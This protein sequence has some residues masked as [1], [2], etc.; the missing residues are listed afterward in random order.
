MIS[1]KEKSMESISKIEDENS[2]KNESACAENSVYY[3]VHIPNDLPYMD[4]NSDLN[5]FGDKESVLQL[6]KQHKRARFKAFSLYHEAADFAM[7]GSENA[8]NN[9]AIDFVPIVNSPQLLGEKPSPFKGPKP[10]DMIILRKSIEKGDYESIEVIIWKNPRYLISSGDTPSIL[11]EGF[12]YNALH[13]AAKAKNAKIAELILNTVSNVNFV[14]LLYGD[15]NIENSKERANVFLDL[16]LNTPDKGLNET[17]LHFAVKYGAAEVVEVLVSY[18]QCDKTVKNKYGKIP[19]EI[20]C[21]RYDISDAKLYKRIK[22]LLEETYYVPVLR[23]EDNSVPPKIGEPFSPVNPPVFNTHPSSPRLE[24]QAYAGPMDKEG[25]EHFRKVWKTPPRSLKFSTPTKKIDS[26]LGSVASMKYKDPLKGLE[27]VGKSLASQ[28]DISWKEYWPFLDS[29]VDIA[30][31]EGLRLLENHLK[32]RVLDTSRSNASMR[33]E[34]NISDLCQILQAFHINS[35]ISSAENSF[36]DE[37][38]S[39]ISKN[40]SPFLCLEKACEVFATRFANNILNAVNG[41][42][43]NILDTEMKQ[44]EIVILSYMDDNRFSNINFK[45]VHCRLSNL[46]AQKLY[47][48]FNEE[49]EKI[50]MF[51]KIE[52]LIEICSKSFDCF[53]SDDES[54]NSKDVVPKK[55]TSIKKQLLCLAH[56]ILSQFVG[57]LGPHCDNV[58]EEDCVEIWEGLTPCT[59]VLYARRSRKN[60]NFQRNN[61]KKYTLGSSLDPVRRLFQEEKEEMNCLDENCILSE[62]YFTPTATPDLSEEEDDDD[63]FD[64]ARSLDDYDAYIEG[65]FPSKTDGAVF[66]AIKYSGCDIDKIVYPNIYLWK[67][68]VAQFSDEERMSWRYQKNADSPLSCT[69]PQKASLPLTSTPSKSWLRITG[70]NSPKNIKR[71]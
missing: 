30:S 68:N 22:Q 15:D 35:S 9:S 16:Y 67:H 20:I 12:R 57:S 3:G 32:T 18:P 55:G 31:E 27:L 52:S 29:F 2:T 65:K 54:A 46:I 1:M 14:Q 43:I 40:F 25:A 71:C 24:I 63:E 39:K 61:S 56:S 4:L 47:Y 42:L 38:D 33:S 62:S 50:E 23:A 44:L 11:Q 70:V 45:C 21:D 69:S 19:S 58:T 66:N 59:C 8:N 7:N 53:S 51:R 64:D 41:N 10:Q 48:K 49:F 37:L 17:P 26:S 28:Y 13:I 34:H 36:Q 6:L 60:A 5:V